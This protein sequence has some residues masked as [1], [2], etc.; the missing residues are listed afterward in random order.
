MAETNTGWTVYANNGKYL[1]FQRENNISQGSK[2][3]KLFSCST[4]LSVKFS[5]GINIKMPTK[6]GIFNIF[7]P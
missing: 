3:I 7:L 2:I 4:Q 6:V 1:V 5:K